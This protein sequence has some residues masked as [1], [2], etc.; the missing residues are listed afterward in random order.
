MTSSGIA[1][2]HQYD[3]FGNYYEIKPG[4]E[5]CEKLKGVPGCDQSGRT[6]SSNKIILIFHIFQNAS[7][8][9]DLFGFRGST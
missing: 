5:G 9:E 7:V 2:K 4:S 3:T 6:Q 1:L 8:M